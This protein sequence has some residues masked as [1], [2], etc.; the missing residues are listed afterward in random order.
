MENITQFCWRY[1]SSIQQWNN[2]ENRLRFEKVIAESL[3][4]SFFGDTVYKLYFFISITSFAF[5]PSFAVFWI[6]ERNPF[7]CHKTNLVK[8][9]CNLFIDNIYNMISTRCI[10]LECNTQTA[11]DW[12][13]VKTTVPLYSWCCFV[14]CTESSLLV[15][16][17]TLH[18]RCVVPLRTSRVAVLVRVVVDVVK[19]N[20]I[21][22]FLA[23]VTDNAASHRL[24]RPISRD[25]R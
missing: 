22:L 24:A 17:Q 9:K 7:K 6:L 11:A 21:K 13:S 12:P 20:H 10:T 2:F 19:S 25:S 8:G 23:G 1:S 4:A 18:C 15:R 5:F 14:Y 16:R 3:V